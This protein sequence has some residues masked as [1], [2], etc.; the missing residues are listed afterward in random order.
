MTTAL[1]IITD[2]LQR[3]GV[4]DITGTVSDA[5]AQK[6]LQLLNDMLDG[7]SNENLMLYANKEYSFTLTVGT[8]RYSI[9]SG[10]TINDTRPL[11]LRMGAGAAFALDS[12]SNKYGIEVVEQDVWNQIGNSGATVTSNYPDTLFYDPQYPLGYINIF[13]TPNLAGVVVYFD[14]LLQL[15]RFSSLSGTLSLPPGYKDALQTNLSIY[16]APFYKPDTWMPSALLVELASSSKAKVKRTNIK[17]V[18][19]SMDSAL[20]ARS[21]A[22]NI[23]SDRFSPR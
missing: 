20:V 23:Y 2:A 9:G 7:W 3:I 10:G 18:I 13:P 1:E 6:G 4:Y 11:N 5:D 21:G 14:A 19:A 17:E 8:S 15:T 16:M 12:N 22:Y